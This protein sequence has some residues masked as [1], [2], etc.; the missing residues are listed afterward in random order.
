MAKRPEFLSF[1][2][3][4][5]QWRRDAKKSTG[6][7]QNQSTF[8][9]CVSAPLREFSFLFGC[10]SAAPGQSVFIRGGVVLALDRGSAEY[11]H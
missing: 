1:S 2:H 9:L 8:F 5:A 7:P 4:E 11:R 3:A 6:I 10:G